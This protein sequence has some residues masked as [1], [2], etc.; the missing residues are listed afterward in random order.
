[1]MNNLFD[2]ELGLQAFY[3]DTL[4]LDIC[5]QQEDH[6]V[7]LSFLSFMLFISIRL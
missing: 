2:L 7:N 5:I 1:M 3:W 4:Y 6:G